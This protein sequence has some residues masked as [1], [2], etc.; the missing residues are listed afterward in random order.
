MGAA[1]HAA[2]AGVQGLL[3]QQLGD[4]LVSG[5][6][7]PTQ[8]NQCVGVAQKPLPVILEQGL[9]GG[10]VLE[11]NGGHDIAGAHGSLE[12]AKVIRQGDIAELVHHQA[13]RDGQGSLVYLVGLIVQSLK[14][15]GV[16]HT[17]QIVKCPVVIRDDGEHGLLTL[18]HEA[19]LHIVP[20][21]DAGDLR[22]DESGKPDSGAQ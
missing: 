5:G 17:H 2:V 6:L 7:I 9:E 13:D 10:N 8:I 20:R 4:I 12:F 1:G 3:A 18:P 14:G 21:S 22:Q 19:Q 11:Y 16:E 15:A